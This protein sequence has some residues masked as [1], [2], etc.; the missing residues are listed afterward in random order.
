VS[1]FEGTVTHHKRTFIIRLDAGKGVTQC[2]LV[3]IQE[4]DAIASLKVVSGTSVRLEREN[5]GSDAALEIKVRW[6]GGRRD[7][8]RPLLLL[9]LGRKPSSDGI[10]GDSFDSFGD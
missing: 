9:L 4:Y 2:V 6:P 5:V 10:S 3:G 1:T 7:H 8:P